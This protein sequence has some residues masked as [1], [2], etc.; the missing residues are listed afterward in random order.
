MLASMNNPGKSA[1]VV[2]NSVCLPRPR[3]MP[4][5][6]YFK[7]YGGYLWIL[8]LLYVNPYTVRLRRYY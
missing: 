8:L 2:S 1:R 4:P 5:L 3:L 7:I 6:Y